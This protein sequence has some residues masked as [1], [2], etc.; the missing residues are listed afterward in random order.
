MTPSSDTGRPSEQRAEFMLIKLGYDC[1]L[2]LPIEEGNQFLEAYSR[3]RTW[4]EGYKEPTIIQPSPPEITVRYI[5]D[6]ELAKV[7]FDN[8]LG[9]DNDE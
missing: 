6:A 3:A 4:K 7:K 2:L 1:K 9:M 5:T 8:M